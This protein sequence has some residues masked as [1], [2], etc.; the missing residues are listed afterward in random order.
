MGRKYFISLAGL[1]LAILFL[2]YVVAKN[3]DNTPRGELAAAA[4]QCGYE[5]YRDFIEIPES[6]LLAADRNEIRGILKEQYQGRYQ[7]TRVSASFDETGTKLQGVRVEL[8]GTYEGWGFPFPRLNEEETKEFVK[9]AVT[10]MQRL[11]K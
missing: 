9:K 11:K 8:W 7:I 5:S 3:R 1:L 2:G 6:V 10:T 4:R